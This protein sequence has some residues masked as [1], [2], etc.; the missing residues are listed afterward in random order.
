MSHNEQPVEELAIRT[1]RTPTSYYTT[2]TFQGKEIYRTLEF[3]YVEPFTHL[4]RSRALTDA[5]DWARDYL[6]N[7]LMKTH[8]GRAAQRVWK[9]GK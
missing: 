8:P 4:P 9:A 5:I 2:V 7:V 6:Y 3:E 1:F